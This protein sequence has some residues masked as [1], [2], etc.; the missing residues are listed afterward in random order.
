[1][2]AVI[3]QCGELGPAPA[4]LVGHM[5]PGLVRGI[6]IGLRE[7]LADGGGDHRVLAF[8]RVRQGIPDP[9]TRHLCQAAP[10]TRNGVAQAVMGIQDYQLDAL[11]A[12]LDQLFAKARPERFGLRRPDAE[13][14]DLAAALGRNSHSDY[15]GDRDDAPAVANLQV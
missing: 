2:L 10:S 11:E 12:T 15:R 14:D 9:R 1:M 5:T 4:Q 3:H 6:G 13:T 8:G 7:G